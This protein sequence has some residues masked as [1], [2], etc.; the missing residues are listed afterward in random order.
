MH[1]CCIGAKL[2]IV[3][4]PCPICGICWHFNYM[5]GCPKCL[6][7]LWAELCIKGEAYMISKYEKVLAN[8]EA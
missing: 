3:E 2:N 1:E 8:R 5:L 4:I 7:E 6:P